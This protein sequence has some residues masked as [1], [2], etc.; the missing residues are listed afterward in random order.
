M[1]HRIALATLALTFSLSP[2]YA[3]KADPAAVAEHT[4]IAT[5][6]AK[7]DLLRPA[8]ADRAGGRNTVPTRP[9]PACN[10]GDPDSGPALLE[11]YPGVGEGS[12]ARADA[13]DGRSVFPRHEVE[14]LLGDQDFGGYHHHRL[15]G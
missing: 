4:A 3:Q 11:Q 2:T 7:S 15:H 9:A 13:G 1:T 8:D 12:A 6:A 5:A 10:D 14:H